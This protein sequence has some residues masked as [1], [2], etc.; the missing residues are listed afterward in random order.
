MPGVQRHLI[1]S[2]EAHRTVE[3]FLAMPETSFPDGAMLFV[4]GNQ[5]GTLVGGREAADNGTLERFSSGLN[6]VAASVSQ[7]G[8][9]ASEGPPDF[10]GPQTQDAIRT[11]LSFLRAQP[12]VDAGRVA[13]HGLS[14]GAVVSAMV[15]SQD[16]SLLGLILVAGNYDLAATYHVAMPG[17]RRAIEREAGVTEKDFSAR[18]PLRH[19]H[20]IRSETLI[21]HG[22]RDDRAPFTQAERM[23]TVLADSGVDVSLQAF[24]CGHGIPREH[25]RAA[26]RPFLNR[27]FRPTIH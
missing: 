5:N 19:A 6:I 18:S 8:F 23:A 4:H 1:K 22:R 12:G 7:P 3:L 9:G 2:G 15:A 10:C 21:I 17:L 14:R 27:M 25:S 16:A 26:M 20:K 11:A 24:D 13:L